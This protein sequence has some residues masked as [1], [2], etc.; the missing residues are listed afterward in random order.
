MRHFA[1]IALGIFVTACTPE[2][3]AVVQPAASVA[4]SSE[5]ATFLILLNAERANAGL[6]AL[7]FSTA[8]NQ[9]AVGH[10]NDMASRGYFAHRSPEGV[11]HSGRI[12]SAGCGARA[13]GETIANGQSSA[14]SVLAGWLASPPHRAILL[15]R[16]YGQI[17]LGRSG[18]TWVA[19]T[20][21]R[22]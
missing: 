7:S 15:D 16:K 6:S 18:N 11:A 12:R 17:G 4:V 9:A 5:Q 19:K 1:I 2:P 22:C 10:A 3:E 20:A 21:N 14:E 8:L 13:T